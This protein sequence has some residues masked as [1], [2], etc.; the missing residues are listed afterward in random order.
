MTIQILSYEIVLF[1][2]QV[3]QFPKVIGFPSPE[4]NKG[5]TGGATK[6]GKW[7]NPE[8]RINAAFSGIKKS[9]RRDSNGNV[10]K[11]CRKDAVSEVCPVLVSQ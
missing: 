7:I 9:A 3:L 5:K 6:T 2:N 1:I 8:T 10:P 4:A 11:K